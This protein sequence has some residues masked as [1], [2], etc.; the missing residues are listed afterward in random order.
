MESHRQARNL[1]SGIQVSQGLSLDT[2]ILGIQ[3]GQGFSLGTP[4]IPK[5]RGFS[6]W[7]TLSVIPAID[8]RETPDTL[9]LRHHI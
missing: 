7:G 8:P 9:A 1:N 3:V 4:I 6:P 2:R 5:Q